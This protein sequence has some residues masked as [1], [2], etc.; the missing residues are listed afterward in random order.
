MARKKE[1]LLPTHGE[2]ADELVET[3]T[4]LA[5][6]INRKDRGGDRHNK[7]VEVCHLASYLLDAVEEDDEWYPTLDWRVI[8]VGKDESKW[9][10][11]TF[12]DMA[13]DEAAVVFRDEWFQGYNRVSELKLERKYRNC[14]EG[15]KARTEWRPV[16]R[17]EM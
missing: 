7:L 2:L 14:P 12:L 9:T 8:A 10:V 17:K 1:S 6:L 15:K 16:D 5:G 13:D 4:R 3:A 11:A